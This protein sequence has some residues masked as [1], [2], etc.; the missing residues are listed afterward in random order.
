M[1]MDVTMS[2]Q[3]RVA[4]VGR[5]G[6]RS[7]EGFPKPLKSKAQISEPSPSQV[8]CINNYTCR[9]ARRVLPKLKAKGILNI[10]KI[11]QRKGSQC[12]QR[13]DVN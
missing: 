12:L 3:E 5:S 9:Y 2:S 6:V 13:S 1:T 7:A 4:P 11:H 10:L 8:P